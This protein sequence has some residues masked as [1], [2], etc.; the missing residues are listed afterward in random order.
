MK[1]MR[2]QSM[3][4]RMNARNK[5]R[6]ND[7]QKEIVKEHV[8][9]FNETFGKDKTLASTQV[10]VEKKKNDSFE[11]NLKSVIVLEKPLSI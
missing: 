6:N 9:N 4:Y 1:N 7:R 8:D 2:P 3:N 11:N 10:C 5:M